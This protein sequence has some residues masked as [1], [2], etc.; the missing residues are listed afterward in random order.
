MVRIG[1][2]QVETTIGKPVE[3][4]AKISAWM[5]RAVQKDVQVLVF[6]ECSL[7]GYDLSRAEAEVLA[8]TIPGPAT[9]DLVEMC[10]RTGLLVVVGLLERG[11]D[12]H[13]YNSAAFLGPDGLIGSYRKTHLPT[14]G[15]DRFLTPG[16]ALEAPFETPLGRFGLL[17]C[18]DLRFPEP[19]RIM[20]LAGAEAIL[21]P[22]SWPKAASFYPDFMVAS[23]AAENRVFVAAA[24]RVGNERGTA[25][26]GRSQIC[27]VRGEV[28]AEGGKECEELLIADCDMEQSET[29][30]LILDPG[31]YELHLVT[32]RRPELYEL[33]CS[34]GE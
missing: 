9:E 6:P 23:R 31:K 30:D 26:L 24:N 18:Y 15:V 2:A 8:Q 4:L 25:S 28:L 1:A 14:L 16:N 10:R 21:L 12:G 32:D 7:T 20:G 3:N 19:A 27:G 33:I 34:R 13:L 29:K 17:I 22:T 5:Q 11:T